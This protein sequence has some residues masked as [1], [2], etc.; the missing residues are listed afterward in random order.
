LAG[1][2]IA[3][4][5][6]P[7]APTVTDDGAYTASTTQLHASWTATD[8][9]TGISEYQYAISSTKLET[10]IISGGGW[11]SSGVQTAQ[12]RTGLTLTRG[13]VYYVLVKAK[14]GAGTWSSAGVADGII[15]VQYSPLTAGGAKVKA[16]GTTVGLSAQTVTATFSGYFYVEDARKS[17]GIRV[18]PI[19]TPPTLAVG[20]K[21][22]VG[23]TLQTI[24][25]ERRIGS[26]CAT[27]TVASGTAQPVDLANWAVGGQ[28]W[29]YDSG[30]GAGQ[31]GCANSLG[32]NNIGLLVTTCGKVGQIGAGYLYLD[33][34][35]GLLDGTTTSGQP[36][37][38][39]RIVCNP[40]GF[41]VNQYLGATGLSSFFISGPNMLPAVQVRTQPAD[42]VRLK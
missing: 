41:A 35:S 15:P 1:S 30:T 16:D 9:Q 24:G 22:D 19:D 32:L 21:V 29:L 31:R 8:A 18:T 11:V 40:A 25:S 27:I 14:N 33:D 2:T 5:T 37:R 4:A 17:L 3:D 20:Q 23:G 28:N 39:I 10:G 13:Q 42:L 38:G 6:P 12:T 36:N 34:G 7:A 26:A